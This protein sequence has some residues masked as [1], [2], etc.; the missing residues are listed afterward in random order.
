MAERHEE[1]DLLWW[2]SP[3]LEKERWGRDQ[4]DI[5]SQNE[6]R[7]GVEDDETNLAAMTVSAEDAGDGRKRSPKVRKKPR[8]AE[9]RR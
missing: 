1:E 5:D 2:S 7:A 4:M 6:R 9:L 8:D 3:R